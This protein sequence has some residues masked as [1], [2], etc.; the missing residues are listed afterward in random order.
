MDGLTEANSTFAVPDGAVLHWISLGM[1]HGIVESW[2]RQRPQELP[3]IRTAA[4][5]VFFMPVCG[6]PMIL[7]HQTSDYSNNH[8]FLLVS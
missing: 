1:A 6:F 7:Q 5:P 2:T 3:Y 4:T 8:A